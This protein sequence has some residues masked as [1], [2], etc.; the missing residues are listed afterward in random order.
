MTTRENRKRQRKVAK[1]RTGKSDRITKAVNKE[2]QE[3]KKD[4]EYWLKTEGKKPWY[5]QS[6]PKKAPTRAARIAS[7]G[8]K[9]PDGYTNKLLKD[10]SKNIFVKK[11]KRDQ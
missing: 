7:E 10:E 4:K 11:R 3:S 5:K 8:I 6:M 9:M 2:I 1:T